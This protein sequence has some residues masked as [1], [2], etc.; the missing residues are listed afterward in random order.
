MGAFAFTPSDLNLITALLVV[1]ALM[2]PKIK[3]RLAGKGPS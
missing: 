2:A 3:S 1:A